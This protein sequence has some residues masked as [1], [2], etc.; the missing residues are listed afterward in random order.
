MRS[1][2]LI[3]ITSALAGTTGCSFFFGPS[4]KPAPTEKVEATPELVARGTYLATHV[5]VCVDCHSP[6]VRNR[7]TMPPQKGLEYAG[8]D[9]FGEDMGVPG[10]M[11]FP[12]I[13]PDEQFGIG[14]WTDGEVIRAIREGVDHQGKALMPG[15][16]YAN[17]RDMSDDD[18]RAIVAYLR[19]VPPQRK[20]APESEFGFFITRVFNFFPEPV[21]GPVPPPTRTDSVKYG[22]YL[23]KMSG[24]KDCHTVRSGASL[25]EDMA[26]AG[27]QE[28]KLEGVFDVRTPN[29]TPDAQT[30]IGKWTKEQFVGRFKS[31]EDLEATTPEIDPSRQTIMPWPL[32][33]GMTEEDL[34]AIYDYLRTVKPITNKVETFRTATAAKESNK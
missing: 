25:D 13:S 29:I 28:F 7:Y 8:G 33:A 3:V 5:M 26:F 12:N 21:E 17:Y 22:E 2:R 30:G 31:F 18:V 20:Q 24:C 27:G 16:P 19:T 32:Y 10:T 14:K 15:M 4:T 23:V 1:L 11:C 9:C 34:S 6:R